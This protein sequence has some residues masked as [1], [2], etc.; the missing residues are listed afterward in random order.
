MLRFVR[1]GDQKK[2]TKNPRQFSMQN[3]QAKFDERKKIEKIHK[4]ILESRQSNIKLS[5]LAKKNIYIYIYIVNGRTPRRKNILEISQL[6]NPDFGRFW[7]G[8]LNSKF[9]SN[10]FLKYVISI[11]TK[12]VFG[13]IIDLL[14]GFPV[15]I[16]E[17]NSSSNAKWH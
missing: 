17:E 9:C 4:S 10:Y 2:F 13:I 7:A 11:S 15:I 3:S 5:S 1:D 8:H 16:A 14:S 6:D 12:N